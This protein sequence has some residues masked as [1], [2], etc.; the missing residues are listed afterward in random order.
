MLI[1]KATQEVASPQIDWQ[2]LCPSKRRQG[3][4]GFMRLRNEGQFLAQSIESWLPVLDELV[5][6][7]NHCQD[8]TADIV[9]HYAQQFPDKIRAF[10]YLPIV[11]PQGSQQYQALDENNPQSLVYYYNFALS[12]TTCQ[13]AIKL[14]GDLI[15]PHTLSDAGGVTY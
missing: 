12:K 10:H 8:N 11:Y 13:W 3:I 4:S 15:L 14:D 5:I 7:Y 2:N 6:V 1:A 9:E